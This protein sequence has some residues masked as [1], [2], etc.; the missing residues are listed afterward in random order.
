MIQLLDDYERSDAADTTAAT[1]AASDA[2][3]QD[4][5]DSAAAG[6]TSAAVSTAKRRQ[7]QSAKSSSTSSRDVS[8]GGISLADR[9]APMK[10]PLQV[11]QAP[12]LLL[13]RTLVKHCHP[14]VCTAN[15]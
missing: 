2:T 4:S 15:L 10:E 3:Q 14:K 12:A 6:S 11:T 7:Q 9:L 5:S 13:A 8:L 1:S